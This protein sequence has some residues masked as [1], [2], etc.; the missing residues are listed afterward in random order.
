MAPEQLVK[1]I[2]HLKEQLIRLESLKFG[3]R[4]TLVLSSFYTEKI[5]KYS[6]AL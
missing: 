5:K 4:N 1:K 6:S 3:I 2:T